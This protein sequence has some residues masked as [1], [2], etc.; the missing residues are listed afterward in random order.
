MKILKE[1]TKSISK[2]EQNFCERGRRIY[3]NADECIAWAQENCINLRPYQI[4]MLRAFCQ[5]REV[6]TARGIGRTTVAKV[7]GAYITALYEQ[8]NMDNHP[9][10]L[11][12]WEAGIQAGYIPQEY[13]DHCRATDTPEYQ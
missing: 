6:H 8:N 5:G 12:P 2:H 9:E 4:D 10:L 3:L 13:V 1:Y 11:I 7:F